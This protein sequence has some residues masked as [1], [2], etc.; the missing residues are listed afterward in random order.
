MLQRAQ[1][2]GKLWTVIESLGGFTLR[3][4]V[5]GFGLLEPVKLPTSCLI[6]AIHNRTE[7]DTVEAPLSLLCPE[8]YCTKQC[9]NKIG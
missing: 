9:G 5:I 4:N 2:L 7:R 8:A 6:F 1:S 3:L